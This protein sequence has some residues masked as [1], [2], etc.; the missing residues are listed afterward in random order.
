MRRT[1]GAL[2]IAGGM[3]VG[4]AGAGAANSTCSIKSVKSIGT[5][6]K[7]K[8]ERNS[9]GITEQTIWYTSSKF[10]DGTPITVS[11]AEYRTCTVGAT[12]Y[13]TVI[14]FGKPFGKST[15]HDCTLRK[16]TVP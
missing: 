10:P 5:V 4:A 1:I 2:I 13:A 8:K 16:V 14:D 7:L 6:T 15:A 12:L 9:F 3:I 11:N